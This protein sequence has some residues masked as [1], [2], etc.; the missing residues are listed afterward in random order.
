MRFLYT[1]LLYISLPFVF[2]RWLWRSRHVAA[3]RH[4]WSERFGFIQMASSPG[5]WVHAVSVGEIIAAI[6]LIKALL[7]QLPQ[8]PLTITTT[9]PT[10]SAQVRKELGHQIAHYYVPYDIPNAVKRFLRRAKPTLAIIMET[11][12]WPNLLHYTHQRGTPI[13]LANA[14]LS[15]QSSKGYQRIRHLTQQMLAH[16]SV[17]AAQSCAD[18][19]RFLT[20]GL[21]PKHL[22][23]AGNIKFDMKLPATLI[24]TGKALRHHWGE[25]PTLIAASTHE[26]EEAIVLA[27]FAAIRQQYPN[28]F[29]ILVPR[30]ADRF[31]KVAK[32]CQHLGYRIVRRSLKESPQIETDILLVDTIGELRLFYCASDIAFIGGSLIP[33]GGHNLIEPAAVHLPIISGEHLHHFIEISQLLLAKQAL[34]IINDSDSLAHAVTHLFSNDTAR[35]AMGE[36]AY[37]VSAANTGALDKHL[38]WIKKTMDRH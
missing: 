32:L 2:L 21:D 18:G 4:R 36:R 31:D 28:L 33:I 30:H 16:L 38:A 37:Q 12:L 10:A 11:E 6:P 17:V 5:I 7:Q 27:A 22:L 34:I 25:R 20:L 26:G 35:H 1:L 24:E 29:L 13:M 9:T 15:A 23:I 19:E 8:Y 3:Y 14:R